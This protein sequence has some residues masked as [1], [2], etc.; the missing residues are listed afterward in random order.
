MGLYEDMLPA[1]PYKLDDT[2]VTKAWILALEGK[3]GEAPSEWRGQQ[4][5]VPT[6]RWM[7]RHSERTLEF[8]E[9]KA[10]A[11]KPFYVANWPLMASFLPTEEKVSQGA[12]PLAGWLAGEC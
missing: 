7:R 12:K 4:L 1:D 5:R 3:K 8:I 10:K 11:G 6:S 2:F 9:R